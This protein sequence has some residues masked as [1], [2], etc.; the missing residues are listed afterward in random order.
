MIPLVFD[1]SGM[2]VGFA[3][4]PLHAPSFLLTLGIRRVQLVTKSAY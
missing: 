4:T 3:L 2:A 1:L